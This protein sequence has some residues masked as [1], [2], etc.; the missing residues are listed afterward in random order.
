MEFTSSKKKSQKDEVMWKLLFWLDYKKWL[1]ATGK[2][3]RPNFF[4][5]QV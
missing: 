4:K 5:S 1:L 3:V 2:T